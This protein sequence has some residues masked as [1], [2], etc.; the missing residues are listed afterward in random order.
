MCIPDSW[1]MPNSFHCQ[2]ASI[3]KIVPRAVSCGPCRLCLLLF[4]TDKPQLLRVDLSLYSRAYPSIARLF[5]VRMNA[6]YTLPA[7]MTGHACQPTDKIQ[8][9]LQFLHTSHNFTDVLRKPF[10]INRAS[11]LFCINAHVLSP[12]I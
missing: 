7:M 1:I 11:T 3:I 6:L 2:R 12:A 5:M 10:S 8:P 9:L 4:Q